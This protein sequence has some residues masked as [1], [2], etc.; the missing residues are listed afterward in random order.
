ME[1]SKFNPSIW[2]MR[3]ASYVLEINKV[4]VSYAELG[5][6]TNRKSIL[7]GPIRNSKGLRGGVWDNP[8]N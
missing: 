8:L 3:T 5:I 2:D 7:C 6:L 1:A 4:E